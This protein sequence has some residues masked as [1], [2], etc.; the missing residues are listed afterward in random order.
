MK[1]ASKK[2][3]TSTSKKR[4]GTN[5]KAAKK[6]PK[7]APVKEKALK[8]SGI[9][10]Q[11]LK[12]KP[13]CKVTFKLPKA[14]ALGARVVS[15]VGDFNNWSISENKMEKL[16]N[17]DFKLTLSLSCNREYQFRYLID[18]NRWENDWFADKYIPNEHGSDD[19]VVIIK[20]NNC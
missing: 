18:A 17:G 11:Y 13:V 19:S 9:Q 3:V 1:K 12:S 20:D 14:A 10:K 16:K 2:P 15:I 6:T 7:A 5:N 8:T 4:V